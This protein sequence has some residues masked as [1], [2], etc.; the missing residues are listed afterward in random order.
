ML[1]CHLLTCVSYEDR[2]MVMCNIVH[3]ADLG[4]T[5]KQWVRICICAFAYTSSI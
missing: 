1:P 5:A 4:N 2:A 3:G